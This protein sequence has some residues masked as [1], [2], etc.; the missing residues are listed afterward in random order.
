LMEV[1]WFWWGKSRE[2]RNYIVVE[3]N[4]GLFL[5]HG[6]CQ[7]Q[8]ISEVCGTGKK[9]DYS[10]PA[11]AV[12]SGLPPFASLS[13]GSLQIWL[14]KSTRYFLETICTGICDHWCVE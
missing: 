11:I 12:L 6:N 9:N 8:I 14:A 4:W 3:I 2:M 5:P 13:D 10:R 1:Q 7:C